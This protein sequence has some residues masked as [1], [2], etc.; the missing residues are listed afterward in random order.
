MTVTNN[1]NFPLQAAGDNV[2]VWGTVG[3]G[4]PGGEAGLNNG[5]FSP[6]D[7]ILGGSLPVTMST[8]A[9][10]LSVS[11]FQNKIF[12]L[13]GT[14]MGNATLV[15]PLSP[16]SVG[17]ATA[18]GGEFVV[19]NNTTNSGGPWSVTVLTA[20]TGSV[21]V[22]VPQATTTSPIQ[23]FPVTCYS[24]GVN[25]RYGTLGLPAFANAVSGNPNGQLAGVAGSIV[26][27]AQL[28]FDYTNNL[29]YVCNFTGP[30]TGGVGTQAGWINPVQSGQVQPSLQGRLTPVPFVPV[31]QSDSVASTTIYY[32]QYTG[33]W[34]A[35]YNGS[36]IVPFQ[37]SQMQL[38]LTSSQGINS[39]Y[40]IFL[41]YNGGT[42]VIGANQASWGSLTARS[43]ATAIARELTSGLWVN[44]PSGTTSLIWNTGSGNTTINGLAPGTLIYLG[45][46]FIDSTSG[47]VSCYTN[48]GGGTTAGPGTARKWGVWNA[49]NR[50][51]IAMQ[52]GD[53]T[54]TGTPA[55]SFLQNSGTGNLWVQ[56]NAAINSSS[57]LIQ[58]FTGLQ[59]ETLDLSY[60]QY[61][62]AP[63]STNGP[64]FSIGVN[65]T[66]S[67]SGFYT[68]PPPIGVASDELP[69]LFNS[70]CIQPP[71]L[72]VNIIYPLFNSQGN[73]NQRIY[74]GQSSMMLISRYNG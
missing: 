9:N 40:D 7:N 3:G 51:P 13:T 60:N 33:S 65:S 25:V 22:A 36:A 24:D 67:P 56:V 64:L 61:G 35:Y 17:S 52:C 50:V 10:N 23:Y 69:T 72:G 68:P 73:Q 19:V 54:T 28:A 42:P 47:Q 63:S 30:A 59:E 57:N 12:I 16:N 49:Y 39:I 20:A 18:C 38:T 55:F 11:N 8:G 1:Y 44:N 2:A 27:N 29:L 53:G 34:A 31:V 74:T 32:A 37:F 46:I 41:A 43:S 58:T 48:W 26:N 21:G 62:I 71:L 5:I 45:S 14:L 70:R 66:T 6:L 15:V 4:S